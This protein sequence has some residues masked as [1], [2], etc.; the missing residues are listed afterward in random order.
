MT[1]LHLILHSI[2]LIIWVYVFYRLLKVKKDM[3]LNL[4]GIML[5]ATVLFVYV[6]ATNI[7]VEDYW[8]SIKLQ[9]WEGYIINFLVGTAF[10]KITQISSKIN[11]MLNCFADKNK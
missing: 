10:I 2:S 6:Y 3:P 5:G 7:M 4:F 1:D 9:R 11:T 8:K